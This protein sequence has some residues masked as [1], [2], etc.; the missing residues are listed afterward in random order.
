[1]AVTETLEALD[2]ARMAPPPASL[3]GA[4]ADTKRASTNSK[5]FDEAM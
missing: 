2:E 1:V 4:Y 5:Q 3:F